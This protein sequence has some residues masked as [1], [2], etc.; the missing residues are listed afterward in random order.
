MCYFTLQFQKITYLLI[1]CHMS[2]QC[3]MPGKSAAIIARMDKER[4]VVTDLISSW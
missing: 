2:N 1:Q 4:S 3:K